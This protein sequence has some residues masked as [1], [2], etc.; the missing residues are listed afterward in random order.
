[1]K[2]KAKKKE[3]EKVQ[4]MSLQI[5]DTFLIF[6]DTAN[7]V[8]MLI[9][10]VKMKNNSVEYNIVDLKTGHLES[11]FLDSGVFEVESRLEYSL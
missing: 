5:G 2:I 6:L 1:M 8:K 3:P 11:I 10:T 4:V 7:D 9:D